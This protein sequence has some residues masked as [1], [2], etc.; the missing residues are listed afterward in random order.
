MKKQSKTLFILLIVILMIVSS[1]AGVFLFFSIT[2]EQTKESG[3]NKLESINS[4]LEKT[5]NRSKNTVLQYAVEIQPYLDDEAALKVFITDKKD[6]ALQLAGSHCLNVFAA[7][8]DWY[9]IPE[10]SL[11]SGFDPTKEIWYEGAKKSGGKPFVSE[12]FADPLTGKVYYTV[13]IML[14]DNRTVIGLDYAMDDIKEL[15]NKL[16]SDGSHK[17]VI[18][19]DDGIIKASTDSK[20]IGKEL[21]KTIPEY[22]GVF[23]L[24]RETDETVN[25]NQRGINTFGVHSELG[26]CLITSERNLTL[27]K[28]S[29]IQF[30]AMTV[31][32]LFVFA[33]IIMMYL[34]G[35]KAAKSMHETLE[36]RDRF[37]RRSFN[38]L[39]EPLASIMSSSSEENIKSSGDYEKELSDI[40]TAAEIL[41][42]RL[43]QLIAV[44]NFIRNDQKKISDAAYKE[45]RSSRKFR[46]LILSALSIVFIMSSYINIF[47]VSDYGRNRMQHE[48]DM[49]EYHLS[50]WVDMQKGTLDIFC[51]FVSSNPELLENYSKLVE[52]LNSIAEQ[53]PD[54]SASYMTSGT[55][56]HTVYVSNGFKP[57]SDFHVEDRPWYKETLVSDEG[58][59]ISEPYFDYQTGSYCITFSERVYDNRTGEFLGI[60]ATD[61]YLDK[62]EDILGTSYTDDGYAFLTDMNGD[63][64]NHPYGFYQMSDSNTTNIRGLP[65]G[66]TKPDGTHISFVN[67]YDG[68]HRAVI[69]RTNDQSKFTIYAVYRVLPVYKNI[70]TYSILS[71]IVLIFCIIYV[72]RLMSSLI[73]LQENTNKKLRLSADAAIAADEAKSG[74]L[75]QMSHEIRTPI[76]AVLGMNEMILRE[77]DD[78]TIIEYAMNIQN[79]GKTLLSLINSILDFSKIEDGKMEIIPVKYDTATMIHDLV[80]SISPRA[81]SK[82]LEFIVRADATLPA[83]LKGDDVRLKQVIS[84][85][86]TN[87]VKYTEKG[88]ITFIIKKEYQHDDSIELYVEVTDTGIGIKEE[89]IPALFESFRRLDEKRNRNIEGTGLGMSIVT[90]LLEM[91]DSKLEVTSVYGEGSTFCFRV[92]QRIASPVTMGDYTSRIAKKFSVDMKSRHLYAPKAKVL[93]VDDNE[94]NLRVA[95]SMLR[96]YGIEP[97]TAGSGEKAIEILKRNDYHIILMDHMM[98]GLDGIEV[99]EKIRCDKLISE[100]TAVIALTANAVVGARE[101]YL[102]AGFDDYLTKPIESR[103]LE[104]HLKHFLPESLISYKKSQPKNHSETPEDHAADSFTAVQLK[105]LHDVCPSLD[106]LTG[107]SYCM[108]SKEFYLDTLEGYLEA[109]KLSVM[110]KAFETN[111]MKQYAIL[112]HSL[113]STS[114]TI[115]AVLLS[116][117]AKLLE[118]AAKEGNEEYIKKN[119]KSVMEEYSSLLDGIRKV[120]EE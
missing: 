68:S 3:I 38:E 70:L 8:P 105:K 54:I 63:I 102:K 45:V 60:F 116:D 22:S 110:E 90:K 89:D 29:Y 91:M 53:Y 73:R 86:L 114:M 67:D 11:P 28:T 2:A 78:N 103:D 35:L 48:L 64:L 30:I 15:L 115:G 26:W 23:S 46:A 107:L 20:L 99:L 80:T 34:K 21:N 39:K 12:S 25:L 118:F 32:L 108:D 9:I 96:I 57:G 47:A 76:N 7:A 95:V 75:A 65:Y 113:K 55:T 51:S 49:Y 85:L 42:D 117:H 101:M 37:L 43:S 97:E 27:Y 19:S 13:S 24:V 41:S 71:I 50:K 119:H 72:Y 17:A 83:E 10:Y 61:Y 81:E 33:F 104:K 111:D 93:V 16:D 74:F 56:S 79:A 77:T 52:E 18:V 36:F 87:A 109:D 66:K 69:A 59:S 98:P 1:F 100:D 40:R 112:A 6:S 4:E 120:L 82:G 14:S 88:T 31:L 5:I 94:M 84:N 106:P 62:L 92:K 58:W 44:S